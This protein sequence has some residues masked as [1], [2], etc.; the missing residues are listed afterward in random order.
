MLI[1]KFNKFQIQKDEKSIKFLDKIYVKSLIKNRLSKN[2][3][4]KNKFQLD[5]KV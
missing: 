5:K 1:H 4:N 3:N 2:L